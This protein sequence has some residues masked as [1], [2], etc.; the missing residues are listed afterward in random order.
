MSTRDGQR[1]RIYVGESDQY[2]GRPLYEWLVETARNEG[3]A[4]ATVLRALEGF[5]SHSRMHTA[6]VLRLAQDLP[7]VIEIIDGGDAI[8]EF[9]R[10][11]APAVEDALVTTEHVEVRRK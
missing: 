8:E 11:I 6:K 4:G 3:L 9:I 10:H 2:K 1:L 7:I 5:G